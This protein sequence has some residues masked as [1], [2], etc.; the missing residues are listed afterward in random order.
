[1]LTN[2]ESTAPERGL[3]RVLHAKAIVPTMLEQAQQ[4]EAVNTS[5]KN[6]VIVV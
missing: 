3:H 1:M 5:V 6:F 2:R 4:L